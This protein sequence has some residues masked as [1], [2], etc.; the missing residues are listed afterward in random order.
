MQTP[1]HPKSCKGLDAIPKDDVQDYPKSCRSSDIRN[2]FETLLDLDAISKDE[3][4]DYTKSCRSSN[5]RNLFKTLQDIDAISK[6]KDQNCP[7]SCKS[8][9]V[10]NPFEA[11]QDWM[12]IN[13]TLSNVKARMCKV[14]SSHTETKMS[15]QGE[16]PKLIKDSNNTPKDES[17]RSSPWTRI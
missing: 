17:K 14:P 9:D 8:L 5:V 16:V 6:D 2:P 15:S 3:D 13:I 4:Q 7:K 10:Q 12:K 11:L 1:L